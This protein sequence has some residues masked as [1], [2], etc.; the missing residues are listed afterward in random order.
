M[1]LKILC[2]IL[3]FKLYKLHA[4][5]LHSYRFAIAYYLAIDYYDW[6]HGAS[7]H[8]STVNNPQA[9]QKNRRHATACLCRRVPPTLLFFSV[10]GLCRIVDQL[11]ISIKSG[12]MT[13]TIPGFLLRVPFHPAIT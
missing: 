8:G 1:F 4:K 7:H 10:P 9:A 3:W 11:S 12:T 2:N 6:P 13:G 5:L